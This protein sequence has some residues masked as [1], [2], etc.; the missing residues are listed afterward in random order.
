MSADD[1]EHPPD[2]DAEM[3]FADE[4]A[5]EQTD[6]DDESVEPDGS[7]GHGRA[8][9]RHSARQRK[10][11]SRY[12]LYTCLHISAQKGLRMFGKAASDAM[13]KEIKQLLHEKKAMH[14]VNKNE[15]SRRQLKKKIRYSC[16]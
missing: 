6:E 16:F 13:F 2:T 8:L 3:F 15:L 4:K 9:P 14:P 5:E 11:P 7:R 12:L 1:S 10:P